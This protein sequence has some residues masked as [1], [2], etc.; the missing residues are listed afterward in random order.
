MPFIV[1]INHGW[2]KDCYICGEVCPVEGIFFIESS[3][4]DKGF[5]PVG[6]Q[7]LAQ[8]TGCRLCELLCPDLAIV[9][10]ECKEDS[11]EINN[12]AASE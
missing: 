11:I 1:E 5:Q 3:V 6:V 10:M 12:K 9:V 8:C 7:N 2:C 4:G